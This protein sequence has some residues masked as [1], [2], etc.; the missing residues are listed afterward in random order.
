MS[1]KKNVYEIIKNLKM[2]IKYVDIVYYC[3]CLYN[4][5]LYVRKLF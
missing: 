4:F 2:S 3:A 5:Y 1:I